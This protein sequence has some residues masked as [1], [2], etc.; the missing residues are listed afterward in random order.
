MT[1][2]VLAGMGRA[3]SLQ[4]IIVTRT[5]HGR[6]TR[7]PFREKTSTRPEPT[8]VGL[9]CVLRLPLPLAF[10]ANLGG[11]AVFHPFLWFVLCVCFFFIGPATL[12]RLAFPL[13]L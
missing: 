4:E 3:C 5:E 13:S 6:D 8:Q 1:K 10:T 12:R 11:V 7:S 9:E 2:E